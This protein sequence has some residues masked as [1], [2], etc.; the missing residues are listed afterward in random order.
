MNIKRNPSGWYIE[1]E[2]DRKIF[3]RVN[4]IRDKYSY[5]EKKPLDMSFMSVKN[6]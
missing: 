6:I 5:L 1:D 4:E 2:E 3:K